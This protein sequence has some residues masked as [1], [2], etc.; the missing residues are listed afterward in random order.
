MIKIWERLG[1]PAKAAFGWS[2]A[3]SALAAVSGVVLIGLSGWFLTASALAGFA[4]AGMAFNHLYPSAG[5]RLAAFARV[6]ARYGEQ[7]V[8]H[9]AILRLSSAL[10]PNLFERGARARRG[11]GAMAS[12]E[13]SALVDDV[14]AVEGGFLRIVLPA[15]A[16]AASA[17]LAVCLAFMADVTT[18]VSALAEIGRASC[19]ER[20]SNCV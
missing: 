19:R 18:G 16:I 9:D 17:I 5:V 14:E 6:S 1:A 11:M 13:L 4:G 2:I 10:R 12:G 15:L 7:I 20:V 3:L 8:G